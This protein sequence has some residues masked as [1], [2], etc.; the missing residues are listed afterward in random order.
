MHPLPSAVTGGPPPRAETEFS[1]FG[2]EVLEFPGPGLA[3]PLLVGSSG[4]EVCSAWPASRA[5]VHKGFEA[6]D[7]RPLGSEVWCEGSRFGVRHRGAGTSGGAGRVS[8]S[9]PL[10]CPSRAGLLPLSRATPPPASGASLAAGSSGSCLSTPLWTGLP[11]TSVWSNLPA[12]REG[13]PEKRSL[14]AA[15]DS[16]RSLGRAGQQGSLPG[17]CPGISGQGWGRSG[18][19][20]LVAS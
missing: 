9:A 7:R 5:P 18:Q 19:G 4:S 17:P 11:P 1:E 3:R 2:Q 13:L 12:D 15:C 10:L 16:G 20:Y 14:G 6:R 8:K